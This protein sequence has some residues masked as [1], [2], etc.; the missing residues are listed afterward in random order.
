L[1]EE[2]AM[3]SHSKSRPVIDPGQGWGPEI[4][5]TAAVM[6]GGRHRSMRKDHI[7]LQRPG[8]VQRV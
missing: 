2:E 1:L 3:M 7:S 8:E 6:G 5:L 4:V